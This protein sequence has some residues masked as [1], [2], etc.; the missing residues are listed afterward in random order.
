[1]KNPYRIFRRNLG[2]LGYKLN[3]FFLDVVAGE[4]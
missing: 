2:V 1:M 4:W 3:L